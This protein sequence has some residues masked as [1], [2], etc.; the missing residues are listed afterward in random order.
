MGASLSLKPPLCGLDSAD[1][2]QPECVQPEGRSPGDGGSQ[3]SGI[4]S[5]GR[6][7]AHKSQVIGKRKVFQKKPL[8]YVEIYLFFFM[9]L[10]GLLKEI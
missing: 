2:W 5:S 6:A 1:E 9:H 4:C 10:L 7:V 8:R 3:G